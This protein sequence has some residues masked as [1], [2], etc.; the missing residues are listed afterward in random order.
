MSQTRRITQERGKHEQHLRVSS[1]KG[2]E[3]EEGEDVGDDDD[4]GD[5][6]LMN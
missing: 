6:D 4:H 2:F 1:C 3:E 5:D